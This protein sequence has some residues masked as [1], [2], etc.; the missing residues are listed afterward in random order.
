[1]KALILEKSK[2]PLKLIDLPRPTPRSGEILIQ[3]HACAICRTDL[4]IL[5]G[6]LIPPHFPL[7]LGHQIV[8]RVA[9]PSKRFAENARVGVP[10]LG[11]SCGHCS[12]CTENKENLCDTGQFTGF[13][14]N[15][16]LAEYCV[17]DE[18]FVF[19]LPERYSDVEAA[20]LLCAGMLGYRSYKKAGAGKRLGFYGFGAAAH[21]LIQV[22][23]YEK[24]EVYAFTRKGDLKG[25]EEALKR[26]AIWAGD[27]ET[28]PPE[29]LDAAIIF[30]PVGSLVPAALAAVRKG[31]RV[32]CA[33]I[34]M[35]D[36][37]SFPYTILWGE[38]SI[39]SVANLTR[40]DGKE[41]LALAEKVGIRP[42]VITYT[43]EQANQAFSDFRSG[44]LQ[45]SAVIRPLA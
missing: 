45:G 32:V 31:G 28:A 2:A 8:G 20:P 22:A 44:K 14:R 18:N 33:G 12:Y 38:R 5:D 17:A 3:V 30:A 25:Q 36:I 21:L 42:E 41:F 19:A 27:S 40:A 34:H 15:G 6:E 43:L 13:N 10:W 39:C 9:S 29:K 35:S 11:K 26:G 37:P 4:H 16:G 1:M 7:I 23:V 24:R